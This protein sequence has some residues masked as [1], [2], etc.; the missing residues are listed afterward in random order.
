MPPVYV[1]FTHKLDAEPNQRVYALLLPDAKT[2]DWNEVAVRESP[3]SGF[4]VF[5]SNRGVVDWNNL[6]VPVA[7]PY[8]GAETVTK[9]AHSLKTLRAVL[10]G[11]FQCVTIAQV[12]KK[13]GDTPLQATE[14]AKGRT[15]EIS[16]DGSGTAGATTSSS[17]P[18]RS[19]RAPCRAR[20]STPPS[21]SATVRS[22]RPST[23][24]H[25]ARG[26]TAR[27]RSALSSATNS[28]KRFR[29]VMSWCGPPSGPC[30]ISTL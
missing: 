30:K 8:L 28:R 1:A 11:G 14:R 2:G 22:C 27:E 10:K 20:S 17:S 19:R 29:T 4:G 7:L 26:S 12:H 18:A 25:T 16:K 9:D 3:L 6:H 21:C 15:R 13:H 5:P 23:L 24:L